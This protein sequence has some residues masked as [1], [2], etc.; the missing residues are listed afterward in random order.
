MTGPYGR[1]KTEDVV[2]PDL[3]RHS[4]FVIRHPVISSVS[5]NHNW[6]RGLLDR[7]PMPVEVQGVARLHLDADAAVN[8]GFATPLAGTA[9]EEKEKADAQKDRHRPFHKC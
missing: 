6:P 3:V 5:S 8:E 1:R 7:N 2:A 9:S 4:S